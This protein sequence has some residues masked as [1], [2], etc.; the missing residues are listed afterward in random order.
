MEENKI[1]ETAEVEAQEQASIDTGKIVFADEV[2]ATIAALAVNDVEGV[3]SMSGNVVSGIS[4]RFGKKNVT[5]GV[6][7]TVN[8]DDV[9]VD[10]SVNVKYGYAIQDVC[11][12]LQEAMKNGIETM[13]GLTV[14]AVNVSVVSVV[15]EKSEAEETVKEISAE[16]E[17]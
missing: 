4:E 17:E 13:T 1:I 3:A 14:S 16:V 7:V 2:I 11:R 5:K 8:A 9:T 15:F 6:K 12:K 10:A